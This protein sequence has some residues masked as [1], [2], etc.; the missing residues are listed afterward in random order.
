[1]RLSGA[2]AFRADRARR[3]LRFRVCFA[4]L[5]ALIVPAW[6]ALREFNENGRE[7]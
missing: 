5:S 4:A 7:R 2:V 3:G 6:D 1:M